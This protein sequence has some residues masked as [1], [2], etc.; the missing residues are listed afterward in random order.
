VPVAWLLLLTVP[1]LVFWWTHLIK[2]SRA[3]GAMVEHGVLHDTTA[4]WVWGAL[5]VVYLVWVVA[6]MVCTIW[7]FDRLGYHYEPYDRQPQPSRRELRRLRRRQRAGTNLLRAREEAHRAA[8]REIAAESRRV[9]SEGDETGAAR[10]AA[11]TKDAGG[12]AAAGGGAAD[13]DGSEQA[14]AADDGGKGEQTNVA[15]DGKGE[16]TNAADGGGD[17]RR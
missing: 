3:H 16:Q 5:A 15:D 13:D 8:L 9:A 12:R 10:G 1:F 14:G 2:I 17:E 4:P 6:L 11:G 7:V